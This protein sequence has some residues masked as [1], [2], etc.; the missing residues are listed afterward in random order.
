MFA[1]VGVLLSRRALPRRF[2][3]RVLALYPVVV[4][5]FF[6][7]VAKHFPWYVIPAYPFLCALLGIWLERLRRTAHGHRAVLAAAL[8]LALLLSVRVDVRSFNPFAHRAMVSDPRVGWRM[9]DAISPAVG[10]PALTL[11]LA[12]LL[13]G[14][15]AL[16]RTRYPGTLAYGLTGLLVGMAACRTLYPLKHTDYQSEMERLRHDL[17]A[18]RAAGE[19]P[20]YPI[21]VTEPGVYKVI[22]YFGDDFRIQSVAGSQDVFYLLYPKVGETAPRHRITNEGVRDVDRPSG[23]GR[24]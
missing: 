18:A 24:P 21:P 23:P 4:I 13:Y 1:V 10:L 2:A 3:R 15:R 11:A 19:I 20:R 5:G 9:P 6:T 14:G 8:I 17:S 12:G 16:L 7:V 22:Y